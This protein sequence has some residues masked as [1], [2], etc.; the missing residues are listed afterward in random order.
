MPMM[1]KFMDW[2]LKRMSKEEKLEMMEKMMPKMMEGMSPDDI[3]SFMEKMMPKMINVMGGDD[4]KKMGETM[5]KM[6]PKMMPIMM[7]AMF[8]GD[9]KKMQEAMSKM[10]PE[11]MKTCMKTMC[12]SDMMDTMH[13]MMPKMMDNCMAQMS[14]PEK[15]KMVKFCHEMKLDSAQFAILH[16]LPGSRLYNILDSENR[17]FTK[18]WSLYDGTHVVFKPKRMHPLEL[19]EKFFWAWKK[20]YSLWRKPYLYPACRYIINRWQK[21]NKSTIVDLKKRFSS[22]TEWTPFRK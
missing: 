20:F 22:A 9:S 5:S 4:Q 19:Q 1:D 8:G 14:Q 7:K 21:V 12:T 17:I 3:A 2:K 10:M 13:E 15:E 16:P 18:D 6:I 11:M